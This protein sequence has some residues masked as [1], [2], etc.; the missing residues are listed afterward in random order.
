M[1][2][3][4]EDWFGLLK[5]SL[6]QQSN[7]DIAETPETST[8]L[9]KIDNYD[10]N[11]TNSFDEKVEPKVMAK[12]DVAWLEAVMQSLSMG[13]DGPIGNMNKIMHQLH[14]IYNKDASKEAS[15]VD[16]DN[17]DFICELLEDLLYI[18]EDVINIYFLYI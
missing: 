5:W 10:S 8:S 2:Q 11:N 3:L 7:N 16:N 17:E 12:A 4:S 14:D 6:R 1:S 15:D 9:I 18:V 13:I